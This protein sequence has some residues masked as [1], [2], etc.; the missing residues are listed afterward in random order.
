MGQTWNA[1]GKH[2]LEELLRLS[3]EIEKLKNLEAQH[4][5]EV[6]ESIHREVEK[7]LAGCID[8]K[9]ELIEKVDN[10]KNELIE[11]IDKKIKEVIE[12]LEEVEN[13]QHDKEL[14]EKII[15]KHEDEEENKVEKRRVKREHIFYIIIVVLTLISTYLAYADF[16][17]KK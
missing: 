5:K 1:A 2:V 10:N 16:I 11:S 7:R 8:H 12:R 4:N 13:K 15:E 3:S 17:H 14:E 9:K 6:Y